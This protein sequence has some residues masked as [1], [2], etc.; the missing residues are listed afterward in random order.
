MA[1]VLQGS[2]MAPH[3]NPRATEYGVVLGGEGDIQVVFPNGTLAMSA[4]VR[5]GDVFWIPRYF[6][7]AQ[8][9]S[10]TGPFEFFGFTTS[11][12]RNRP[13]FLAGATSVLRTML[14]PELAASFGVPEEELR[15]VVH[16]Q[17]EAVILPP[18]Q[19]KEPRV[20]RQMVKE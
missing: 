13:Q 1:Y 12:R 20:I 6:P 2:M 3:V 4:T 11:A 8:V 14:G 18:V 19:E 10:Q 15:E 5:P 16:A 9:A 17:K 7:F